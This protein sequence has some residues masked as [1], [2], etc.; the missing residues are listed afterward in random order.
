MLEQ[1]T[2]RAD[3]LSGGQQQR[4]AIA[5]ALAQKPRL[6]LA[7]EPVASLDPYAAD[8][9]MALLQSI[10]R[11]ERVAIVCSLHQVHFARSYASRII[12]LSRGRLVF[13]AD[14][15]QFDHAAHA[16]LYGTPGISPASACPA[17]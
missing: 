5:R 10:A 8:G 9:V 2:R 7:D 14:A 3:M 16:L 12:G 11:S 15:D 4:V 1:A 17:G 13:S 6:I